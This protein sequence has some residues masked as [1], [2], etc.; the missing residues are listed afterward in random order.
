MNSLEEMKEIIQAAIDGKEIEMQW[1][2][3]AWIHT[4]TTGFN[5]DDHTYRV[6][7]QELR[8]VW[9]TFED[10]FVRMFLSEE[11]GLRYAR[12]NVTELIQMVEVMK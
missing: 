2:D 4:S 8:T 11:L 1:G 10:H 5:F 9:C 3:G 6:K 12:D 7:P